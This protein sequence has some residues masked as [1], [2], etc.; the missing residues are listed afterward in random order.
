MLRDF[1]VSLC[2]VWYLVFPRL[3]AACGSA[4]LDGEDTI[5]T[6]C[7]WD[8][9]LTSY[10]NHHENYVVELFAARFPFKEASALMF[11]RRDSDFRAM[12]HRMKYASRPDIAV[13]MGEIYGRYLRESPLYDDV[14]VVIPVPLHWTKR[15]KRGYNQSEQ[16]ATGIALSMGVSVENGAV[17]RCRKTRTQAHLHDNQQRADNVEGAFVVRCPEKLRGMN[18]LIVDDVI[19][20]GATIEACAEAIARADVDA[21][22]NIGALAVVRSSKRP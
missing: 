18:V 12:I 13:A 22:I 4:L 14:Q 9:P 8:M 2:R 10:W 1:W 19:T 20:T 6:S 3:C 11:F 21:I 7:R 17:G 15:V 16:F 5:C